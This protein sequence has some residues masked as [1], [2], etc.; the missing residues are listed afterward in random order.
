[1][2]LRKKR[3]TEYI[4]VWH[5]F[6]SSS[7][8]NILCHMLQQECSHYII[9][10]LHHFIIPYPV[11]SDKEWFYPVYDSH[12][13]LVQKNLFLFAC[14]FQQNDSMAVAYLCNICSREQWSWR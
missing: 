1:M 8:Y 7:K 11:M 4:C 3:D 13:N 5:C 14:L 12:I 9:T 6:A 2:Y 10:S